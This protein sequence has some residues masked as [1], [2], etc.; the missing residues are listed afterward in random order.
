[1]NMLRL[2]NW[3]I[4]LTIGNVTQ[5]NDYP[6]ISKNSKIYILDVR[7][8]TWVYTFDVPT[9]SSLPT[10]SPTS[11]DPTNSTPNPSLT[12]IEI[13]ILSVGL[14]FGTAILMTIGFFGYR[15]YKR[16]QQKEEIMRVHGNSS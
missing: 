5:P 10:P 9:T 14:I 12:T 16:R 3:Q 6:L 15:Y 2:L 11:D 4:F 8:Y 13:V 1:M 7:S